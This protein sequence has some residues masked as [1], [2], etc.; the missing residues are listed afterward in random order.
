MPAGRSAVC[1][2]VRAH[3]DDPPGPELLYSGSLLQQSGKVNTPPSLGAANKKGDKI[4]C[5][6]WTIKDHFSSSKSTT[7]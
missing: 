7:D 3:L 5:M 6:I 4:F 2:G 1:S